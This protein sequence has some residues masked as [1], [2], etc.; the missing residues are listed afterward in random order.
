MGSVEVAIRRTRWD[1]HLDGVS[2]TSARKDGIT[3]AVDANAAHSS[4]P[5]CF[6]LIGGGR[7][8]GLIL[9]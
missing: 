8:E 7:E 4:G 6:R 3:S 2:G 5:L 9:I 1:E